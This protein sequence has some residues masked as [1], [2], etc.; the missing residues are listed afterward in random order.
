MNDILDN[1]I[2]EIEEYK[3]YTTDPL[4]NIE[5]IKHLITTLENEYES[6][7]EE[8]HICFEMSMLS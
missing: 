3:S 2:E 4:E 7:A 6:I 1:I 5:F 8:E